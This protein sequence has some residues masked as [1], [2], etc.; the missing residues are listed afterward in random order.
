MNDKKNAEA[1]ETILKVNRLGKY[2]LYFNLKITLSGQNVVVFLTFIF[3]LISVSKKIV[4]S[5][6]PFFHRA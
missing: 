2:F 4:D 3:I 5:S 6:F 1:K